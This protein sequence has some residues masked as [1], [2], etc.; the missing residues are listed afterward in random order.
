M[1]QQSYSLSTYPREKK[2]Y[3]FINIYVCMLI[4]VLFVTAPN[5]KYLSFHQ[6]NKLVYSGNGILF[7]N[8]K[9]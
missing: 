5:W 1:T 2:A 6:Q 7:S 3:V 8:K 4:A 9:E